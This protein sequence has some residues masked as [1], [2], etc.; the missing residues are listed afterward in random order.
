MLFGNYPISRGLLGLALCCAS[1]LPMAADW[2]LSQ[3]MA[4]LAAVTESRARFHEE[5]HLAMLTEPLQLSGTLRYVR[6][7]QIEKLVTQPYEESL[8]INGGRLE[9]ETQGRIRTLSLRSQPQIWA[10]VESLRATLAGD[11]PALQRHYKVKLE[12]RAAQWSITLEPRYESLSQYIELIRLQGS[13]NQVH[14]VEII[15]ASGDR[16]DMHIEEIRN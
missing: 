16:S 14:Q 7:D 15:E 12:G 4:G 2:G 1:S 8:R 10:L 6:P 5:K 3:L 9:W 13:D 11:L